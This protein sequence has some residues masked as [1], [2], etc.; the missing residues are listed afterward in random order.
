MAE[1]ETVLHTAF[2]NASH[3]L[4]DMAEE[5]STHPY[6]PVGSYIANYAANEQ[7]V[8]ALLG[9]FFGT[10]SLLF[11]ATFF[12]AK[13]LQPTLTTPELL[14]TLWFTLSGCIHLFFEGYYASH[15]ATLAASQSLIAQM[16]KEY[17]FSDS[18]YL[19][20]NS[21]VLCTETITV[22]FWG[23]GSLLV[24][25]LVVKRSC[26]RWPL[27]GLVS[28]GQFYGDV[29]YYATCW[30]D[31]RVYGFTYSRP[32]AYYFWVYFVLMNAFWIVI[33]GGKCHDWRV[34]GFGSSFA[35][36]GVEF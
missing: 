28:M 32:E 36:L 15:F 17:A 6:Y 5:A 14:T 9:V 2:Q 18:R 11:T 7:S 13:R 26:W 3:A 27:Q 19:T 35:D 22:L 21:F 1:T 34:V 4:Q 31:H 29:L 20:R 30:F 33:P 12:L 8:P 10:C 16:W 23:P 24:A 25:V